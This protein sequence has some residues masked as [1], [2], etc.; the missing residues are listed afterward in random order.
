MDAALVAELR[1]V[2]DEYLSAF[3]QFDTAAIAAYWDP[4]EA[5]PLYIAEEADTPMMDHGAIR[6]YWDRTAHALG[7]IWLR[8][9]GHHAVMRAADFAALTFA[10][11]WAC[12][13]ASAPNDPPIGGTVRVSAHLR[14]RNGRWLFAS[15]VEA[16]LAP[17]PW[18]RRIYREAGRR[19]VDGR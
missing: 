9:E 6:N 16:P 4:E 7:R 11:D 1:A 2:L 3:E 10:M 14:R 15:W 12:G 18:L 8:T 13:T 5:A 19:I 17:L